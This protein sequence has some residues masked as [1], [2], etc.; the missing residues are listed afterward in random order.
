MST[1]AWWSLMAVLVAFSGCGDTV[2]SGDKGKSL[3]A[4]KDVPPTDVTMGKDAPADP[5]MTSPEV[6]QPRD[7]VADV[8]ATDAAADR[9][10]D[11]TAP[12]LPL[13]IEVG[14][15]E[16]PGALDVAKDAE[17]M[18][19]GP[20]LDTS[21]EAGNRDG[22]ALDSGDDGSADA[23]VELDVTCRT[24]SDCCITIDVCNARAY[25]YSKAPGATPAPT[26]PQMDAGVCVTCMPPAV[27]VRCDNRQC[28]GEKL[29]SIYSGALIRDHCGPVTVP[30][31]GVLSD[32]IAYAG[33][34][35]TSWSCAP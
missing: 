31:A 13:A 24:D 19:H 35:Q 28:V 7:V 9:A 2:S 3:D 18:D 34:A 6:Q 14:N 1:K 8:P 21:G 16:A 10:S 5:P 12:D 11:L 32:K 4:G 22:T 33:T 25:L 29:S 17:A 23:P 15:V 30:D 26:F 27:Q 20:A